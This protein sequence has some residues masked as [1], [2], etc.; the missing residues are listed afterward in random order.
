MEPLFTQA[1]QRLQTIYP[2]TYAQ[3]YKSTLGPLSPDYKL[4]HQPKAEE[5][6]TNIDF[7]SFGWYISPIQAHE[8]R[9]VDVELEAGAPSDLSPIIDHPSLRW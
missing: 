2:G 4:K 7:F 5:A 6:I 8:R 3:G 9:E 1:L